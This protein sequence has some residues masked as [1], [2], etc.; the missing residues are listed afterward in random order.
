MAYSSCHDDGEAL[1]RP[2]I[3][4]KHEWERFRAEMSRNV[5]SRYSLVM[6]GSSKEAAH[7]HQDCKR[8]LEEPKYSSALPSDYVQHQHG[9]DFGDLKAWIVDHPT[10]S[11]KTSGWFLKI[12][13]FRKRMLIAFFFAD[14]CRLQAIAQL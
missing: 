7:F 12:A 13:M 14:V 3:C 9:Y 4:G 6:H 1:K 10:D 8:L 2:C 5:L 11:S